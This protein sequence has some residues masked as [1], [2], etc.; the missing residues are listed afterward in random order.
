MLSTST[1][2]AVVDHVSATDNGVCTIVRMGNHKEV[3]DAR[4]RCAAT[5]RK[6]CMASK[7]REQ[8]GARDGDHHL[9]STTPDRNKAA[10]HRAVQ[11]RSGKS[12]A[13][14]RLR[15]AEID[16]TDAINLLA[17]P[18][19][20]SVPYPPPRPVGEIRVWWV[21]HSEGLATTPTFPRMRCALGGNMTAHFRAINAMVAL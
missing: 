2:Q 14:K 1:S 3:I 20:G 11:R 6:R 12:T 18:V 4:R 21:H 16:T 13:A 19:H 9:S 8:A 17:T 5:P 10:T 7:R 15:F